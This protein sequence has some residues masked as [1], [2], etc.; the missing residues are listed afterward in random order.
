MRDSVRKLGLIGVGLWAMTEEKIDEMVTDLVDKGT[1]SKEEGKKVIQDVLEESK[2]QKVDLER[3][4]SDKI[5]EAISKKDT[6]TRRDMHEL[7]SRIKILED[8]I[9]RMKNKEKIFFK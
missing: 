4:I 9:Q 2:K 5:Q 7:Q 8:E 6:F 3:K 1:I